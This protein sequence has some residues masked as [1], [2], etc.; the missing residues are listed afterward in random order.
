VQL[1]QDVGFTSAIDAV[2]NVRTLTSPST[3]PTRRIDWV[4]GRGVRF[5]SAVALTGVEL[6]DHLPLVVVLRP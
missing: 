3:G 4:W 5:R 1:L 2:G 6:S